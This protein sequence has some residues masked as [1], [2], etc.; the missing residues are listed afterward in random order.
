MEQKEV[1]DAAWHLLAPLMPGV[2]GRG[3]GHRDLLDG[4]AH[5]IRTGQSWRDLPA[6]YGPWQSYHRRY[7]RW[8]T[9]GTLHQIT[10]LTLPTTDHGWQT[11]PGRP[12]QLQPPSATAPP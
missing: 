5:T 7:R 12:P 2:G 4:I 8:L 11:L 6:P 9:D 3:R 1:S 10:T